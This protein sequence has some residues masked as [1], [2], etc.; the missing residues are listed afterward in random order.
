VDI[1]GSTILLTGATGGIGRTLARR[2]AAARANLVITGRRPDALRHLARDLG[3]RA[4]VADM[5][6]QEQVRQLAEQCD[7]VD[8]LVANAALPASGALLEYTP[9]QVDRA[10]AVNL[11]APMLLARLLAP[12]MV[13]SGRGHL[14][15]VG[16]L[17][18]K[19]ATRYSSLYTASKF[20]LRGFAH[21]LRQDLRGTGVTVSLIQPGFVGDAGMFA[22]TGLPVPS[23]VRAV[24]SEQVARAVM[25]AI[26]RQR[27]EVNIAPLKLRLQCA[28]AGQFPRLAER[29]LGRR[30]SEETLLQ[31]VEAQRASR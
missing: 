24:T 18:G 2:L 22:D 11:L 10:L 29:A 16:S 27:H 23:G 25:N 26:E 3:A 8:I 4:I 30:G 1:A 15:F 5:A 20:G 14:T 9:K 13:E 21:A 12:G 28:V 31:V 7:D 19:A 17:S 6:D